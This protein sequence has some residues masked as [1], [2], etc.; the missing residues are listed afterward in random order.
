MA[1]KGM[2]CSHRQGSMGVAYRGVGRTGMCDV[3]KC[4]RTLA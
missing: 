4:A 2:G 3:L 1:Y